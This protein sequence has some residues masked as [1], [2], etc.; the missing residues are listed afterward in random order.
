MK[1]KI[2][3]VLVILFFLAGCTFQKEKTTPSF[4]IHYL[5]QP[6]KLFD[7]NR[8]DYGT[9]AHIKKYFIVPQ[10]GSILFLNLT[11]DASAE[12]INP[13]NASQMKTHNFTYYLEITP[14]DKT[15]C[16][17]SNNMSNTTDLVKRT[18]NIKLTC[19]LNN[20]PDNI[21]V[22]ANSKFDAEKNQVIGSVGTGKWYLNMSYRIKV[23]D[24]PPVPRTNWTMTAELEQYY[25][26]VHKIK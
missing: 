2:I 16:N 17:P 12:H 14:P 9:E 5:N 6:V 22:E 18:G 19:F 25:Y 4:K 24:F 3:S 13:G 15:V 1:I 20:P 26:I 23:S 21:T 7:L 10:N 11:W 8:T